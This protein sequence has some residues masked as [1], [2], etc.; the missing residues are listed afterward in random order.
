[1]SKQ[2]R[3]Q[4]VTTSGKVGSGKGDIAPIGQIARSILLIRGEKVILDA[5][6]AELYGAW[7]PRRSIKP[8][9]GTSTV[10]HTI[11]CSA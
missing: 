4:A 5:D 7:K 10:S 11:S 8:S 3:S 6:L 1:M 2:K 9:S